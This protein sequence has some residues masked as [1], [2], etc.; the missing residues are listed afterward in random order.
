[1][2]NLTTLAKVRQLLGFADDST[3]DDDLIE[4][5]LIPAA[6]TMI[7]NYCKTY[8]GTLQ[9]SIRLDA[10]RPY[11]YGN[12]L[13]FR[14]DVQGVD[15][16]IVNAT[17]TLTSA[18]YDLLPYNEP[19][20]AMARL[21]TGATWGVIDNEGAFIITGTLGRG[22]NVPSD[23][24]YAATRLT[25]WLYQTRDNKGDIFIADNT[26]TIPAEAPPMV[27]KILDMGRY[28]K[29]YFYA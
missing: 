5:V 27:F 16:F 25:T 3:S 8:F 9:S 10:N 1:M 18:D 20:Y 23:V 19:P 29:D 15:S 12:V 14:T 6:S 22:V 2:P 26:A 17:N 7:E 4:D 21:R 11:L 24:Q 13:Y 28:V